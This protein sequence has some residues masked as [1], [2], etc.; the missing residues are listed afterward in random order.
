MAITKD[1]ELSLRSALGLVDS[2]RPETLRSV[3][4]LDAFCETYHFTGSRQRTLTEVR[5]V[6]AARPALRFLLTAR[7]QQ[8]ASAIN[9]V[10]RD[11]GAIPQLARHDGLGWHLHAVAED[12]PL[13][14]RIL[15]ETAMAMSELHR[16]AECDR[17][18]SCEASGCDKL[19]LDL[20][21][22]RSKRFCSTTCGNR[23]AA[24]HYRQRLAGK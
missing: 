7:D 23:M 15:V 19:V 2:A 21:R 4:D 18:S 17:I 9:S 6:R 20:S 8:G 1:T 22:N 13:A 10:L 16:S 24:M 14:V 5:E 3:A 11:A 12:A